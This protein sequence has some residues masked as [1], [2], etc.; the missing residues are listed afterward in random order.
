[1]SIAV[2]ISNELATKA[3]VR[4]KVEK[5]SLAKQIEYWATTGE[6]VEENPDL[7]YSF[8]KDIL[9]GKEEARNKCLSPYVFGEGD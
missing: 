4:S 9:V 6:L 5:R 7:P 1:M 3:K 8:I 2:K